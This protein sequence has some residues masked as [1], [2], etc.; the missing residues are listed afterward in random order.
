MEYI[1]LRR[2]VLLS[3]QKALLGMIYPEIRAIGVGF[4]NKDKF[5]IVCYL[6][7]EPN[8]DDYEILSDVTGEILSD[9]DFLE[10]EEKCVFSNETFLNLETL[11]SWVY[12]RKEN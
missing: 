9:I 11:D 1:E 2:I 12:K 5:T 7:R 3:T 8:E 6:D 10:V 4:E